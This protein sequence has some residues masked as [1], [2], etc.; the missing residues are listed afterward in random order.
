MDAQPE[1]ATSRGPGVLV[2]WPVNADAPHCCAFLYSEARC[3][4]SLLALLSAEVVARDREELNGLYVA[5]TRAKERLIVS[6]TEPHR[7]APGISWWQRVEAH[8]APW[9]FDDETRVQPVPSSTRLRL[10]GLPA[11]ER[12]RLN[13]PTPQ[14]TVVAD[15][16]GATQRRLGR[17]VHR[18][19]EWATPNRG[20]VDDLP[21]LASA[22]AREFGASADEVLNVGRAILHSEDC[23]RFFDSAELCWAGNEVPVSDGDELLRIDRLVLF[24]AASGKVW[25]VLDYKLSHQP[26]ELPAYRDQLLRYRDTIAR[27]EPHCTVRCAFLTGRGQV[28]EMA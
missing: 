9:V 19:L 3:P 20:A 18:F 24:E 7:Q 5:M 22:A 6:A 8:A 15:E 10:K 27:L 26:E 16:P 21:Q 13:D 25:W 23:A 17:G 14:A 1:A 2:D 12:E 11:L 4:E 28:I